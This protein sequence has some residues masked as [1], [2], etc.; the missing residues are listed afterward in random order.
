MTA[1]SLL[2]LAPKPAARIVSGEINLDGENILERPESEMRFVRGQKI[3]MIPAGPHDLSE[4]CVH[5]RQPRW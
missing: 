3:S 2:R 1:L 4:P 5:R